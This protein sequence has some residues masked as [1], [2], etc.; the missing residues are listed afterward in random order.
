MLEG[1]E[2]S[3]VFKDFVSQCLTKDPAAR[4]SAADLLKHP[5][6]QSGVHRPEAW[7]DFIHSKVVT[8]SPFTPE[9][10][11]HKS[12]SGHPDSSHWAHPS[13]FHSLQSAT[14]RSKQL[15]TSRSASNSN[16]PNSSN[17]GLDLDHEEED[18]ET[19][20]KH[21]YTNTISHVDIDGGAASAPIQQAEGGAL[22]ADTSSSTSTP[23]PQEEDVH[24]QLAY[25]K[26]H[27]RR[28][29]KQNDQLHALAASYL[30]AINILTQH[31]LPEVPPPSP[32]L[33]APVAP[34]AVPAAPTM[35]RI[36]PRELMKLSLLSQPPSARSHAYHSS[37]SLGGLE[38]L[39][40]SSDDT[41][42]LNVVHGAFSSSRSHGHEHCIDQA[43]PGG[44]AV[45]S[46]GAAAAAGDDGHENSCSVPKQQPQQQQPPHKAAPVP[47]LSLPA[48]LEERAPP[49]LA[50]GAA[51]AAVQDAGAPVP[52]SPPSIPRLSLDAVSKEHSKSKKRRHRDR[53]RDRHASL[54]STSTAESCSHPRHHPHDHGHGHKYPSYL[55][56]L[57]TLPPSDS[58]YGDLLQPTLQELHDRIQAHQ[59][60]SPEDIRG[61]QTL[62]ELWLLLSISLASIHSYSSKGSS[63]DMLTDFLSLLTA[64]MIDTIDHHRPTG[65]AG[66]SALLEPSGLFAAA[67]CAS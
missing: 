40:V 7:K 61:K 20:R 41:E 59:Y 4:P 30:T 51:P 12:A 24:Q 60:T 62:E 50:A 38:V 34:I 11:L 66:V 28:L 2:F 19:P 8:Q 35:E 67:P 53:N 58:V 27:S 15:L 17:L 64:Y 6:I 42:G 48:P 43:R 36:T 1:H 46:L 57:C 25:Y 52:Y 21:L 23:P 3:P 56:L 44:D 26:A 10:A 63:R 55:R 5:F 47:L 39:S 45:A 9:Q 16:L 49:P 65:S 14:N 32:T 54:P 31:S 22:Y 29:Q 18:S 33:V 13:T 37:G